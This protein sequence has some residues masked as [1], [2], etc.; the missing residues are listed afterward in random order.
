MSAMSLNARAEIGL[1]FA[2]STILIGAIRMKAGQP[3][4]F[5]AGNVNKLFFDGSGL[6]YQ[7]GSEVKAELLGTGAIRLAEA[8][9]I[10][11]VGFNVG[12]RTA[13]LGSNLPGTSTVNNP[14]RWIA[15]RLKIDGTWIEGYQPFWR[16][17]D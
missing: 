6:A 7:S 10:S 13:T 9:E 15:S 12:T 11:G 16:K 17:S 8:V 4:L 1:D 5:D 3:I 14:T 2:D